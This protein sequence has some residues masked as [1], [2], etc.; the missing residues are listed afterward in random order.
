MKDAYWFKHDSNAKDDPKCAILIEELG[1]EGY[2]IFWVLVETLRDQDGYKC[3]LRMMPVIARRYGTSK[4]KVETVIKNYG[5]FVVEDD[6]F[7]YSQSLIER[8]KPLEIKKLQARDAAN[9][10]WE[11]QKQLCA[12]NADAL[13]EHCDSN[14]NAMPLDKIR[15]EESRIEENTEEENTKD[16]HLS[17]DVLLVLEDFKKHRKAIKKPLTDRALELIVKKLNDL[18]YN[19]AEKILMLEKS[20]ENGWAGVFQLK[21]DER[22]VEQEESYPPSEV[23]YD[24]DWKDKYPEDYEKML[25]LHKNLF[26]G[27]DKV[28]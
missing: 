17:D 19:D 23:D 6:M 9:K 4:Q 21:D 2:G 26:K 16:N 15:E 24:P 14:A 7:F 8:M 25:N 3:P 27:M 10:R 12:S 5:L 20:I 11:K 28:W 1:L 22:I 18:A 13:P